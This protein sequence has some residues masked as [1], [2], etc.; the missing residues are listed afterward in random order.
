MVA[1]PQENLAKLALTDKG[2][3][4]TPKQADCTNQLLLL[5]DGSLLCPRCGLRIRR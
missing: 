5:S 2:W 1:T 4:M 3:I